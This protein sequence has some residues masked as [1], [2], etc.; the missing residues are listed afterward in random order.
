[1]LKDIGMQSAGKIA[2]L[3]HRKTFDVFEMVGFCR[4]PK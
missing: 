1:M 4:D 2:R 3:E